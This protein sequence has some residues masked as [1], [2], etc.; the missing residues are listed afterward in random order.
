M[1]SNVR[2]EKEKFVT[3]SLGGSVRKNDNNKNEQHEHE[4]IPTRIS[5][6]K[7]ETIWL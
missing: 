4:G 6:N 3:P 5:F 7:H 2:N 1:A